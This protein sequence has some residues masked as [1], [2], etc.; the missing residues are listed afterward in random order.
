MEIKKY[1]KLFIAI[2]IAVTSFGFINTINSDS[3]FI[4]S[5]T[6]EPKKSLDNNSANSPLS[7]IGMSGLSGA[8]LGSSNKSNDIILALE[9]IKSRD[10]F[11]V[12]ISTDDFIQ[13]LNN[14][15]RTNFLKSYVKKSTKE[16]Q[17]F[18][19]MHAR[20]LNKHLSFM[21]AEK[22]GIVTIRISHFEA[23]VAKDWLDL[24]ILNLNNSIRDIRLNESQKIAFFLEKEMANQKISEI[25]N[26][27]AGLMAKEVK[28]IALAGSDEAFVFQ[29][30]DS[31]RVPDR[32]ARPSRGLSIITWFIFSIITASLTVLS[33][34]RLNIHRK[35]M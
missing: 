33:L 17:S 32:R 2:S 35:W 13:Q 29:T 30:I 20:F 1:I 6:L 12:I 24:I 4:S 8:F 23:Q 22:T 26:S 15:T 27:L 7:G 10:F 31:P 16:M 34:M 14:P 18:D 3:I 5:A 28:T 11:E 25:R 9:L 21:Q 19:N